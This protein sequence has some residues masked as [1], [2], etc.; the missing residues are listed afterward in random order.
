MSSFRPLS[1][2]PLAD[3]VCWGP[4]SLYPLAVSALSYVPFVSVPCRDPLSSYPFQVFTLSH[5]PSG[6][7]RGTS[8]RNLHFLEEIAPWRLPDVVLPRK[9]NFLR[10]RIPETIISLRKWA[11]EAPGFLFKRLPFKFHPRPKTM[12][13]LRNSSLE[14]R[15]LQAVLFWEIKVSAPRRFLLFKVTRKPSRSP[16]GALDLPRS[17]DRAKHVTK[18]NPRVLSPGSPR[19]PRRRPWVPPGAPKGPLGSPQG[20]RRAPW[21]PQRPL[22]PPRARRGPWVPPGAP[23]GPLG[24]WGP[25]RCAPAV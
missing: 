10:P 7:G 22:G 20:A 8:L 24:P 23:K 12:I 3:C 13:L 19:R 14:P 15:S 5:V 16:E 18:A 1:L 6:P 4:L 11:L 17:F 2:Y 9:S 21:G 25:R